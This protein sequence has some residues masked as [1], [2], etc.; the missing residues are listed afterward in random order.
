MNE[1]LSFIK[2]VWLYI[3]IRKK[4]WIAPLILFFVFLSFLIIFAE[5]SVFAPIIYTF[6]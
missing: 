3:K 4:W 5:T 2:E 6:F 1:K